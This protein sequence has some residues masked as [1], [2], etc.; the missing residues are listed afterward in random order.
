[1]RGLSM[2]RVCGRMIR[3]SGCHF[4]NEDYAADW[5]NRAGSIQAELIRLCG[6]ARN[7]CDQ[8]G[9]FGCL[10]PFRQGCLKKG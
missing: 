5:E 1:M 4:A 6:G 2:G 3:R 10:H 8:A 7:F 9:T